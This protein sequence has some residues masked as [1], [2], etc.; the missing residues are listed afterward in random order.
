MSPTEENYRTKTNTELKEILEILELT[1][2]K[3]K[4]PAK[5]N[6]DEM[7]NA[8][9]TYKRSQDE[10]NCIEPEEGDEIPEETEDE[11]YE[12]VVVPDAKKK[13]PA[14]KVEKLALLK[15]DLFRKELV[16]VHDSQTSQTGFSSQTVSWGNRILGVQNDVV[17]FGTPWYVRRGA[18]KNLEGSEITENIQEPG[19]PMKTVTRKR[20][21]ITPVEGWTDE[22]L[23]IRAQDQKIRDARTIY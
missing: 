17:K 12:A 7:V 6:K 20:Y 3:A 9:M 14:S 11:D 4:N 10:I 21:L 18:L 16:I 23:A 13:R 1:T 8:L 19:G 22:E 2:P 15:A 5:P